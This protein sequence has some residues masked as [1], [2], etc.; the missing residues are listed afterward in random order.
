MWH[1]V[2]WFMSYCWQAPI[3]PFSPCRGQELVQ[4][5]EEEE[6]G[7]EEELG[8]DEL[9]ACTQLQWGWSRRGFAGWQ[10]WAA[11][12]SSCA[13]QT[14][15][16]SLEDRR[17][18]SVRWEVCCNQALYNYSRK[19]ETSSHNSQPPNKCIQLDPTDVVRDEQDGLR[20]LANLL[21]PKL[22]HQQFDSL[23]WVAAK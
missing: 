17:K 2:I 22:V 4:C 19:L 18:G 13:Q 10:A 15:K 11:C 21:Q 6:G 16:G 23:R 7:G 5:Q 9:T 3:Q 20:R 1:N 14:F 12:C 8:G